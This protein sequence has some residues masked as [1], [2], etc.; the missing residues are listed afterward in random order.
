[1]LWPVAGSGPAVRAWRLGQDGCPFQVPVRN[2]ARS[3]VTDDTRSRGNPP[4]SS[5][6]FLDLG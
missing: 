1:M 3:P 6:Q 2:P 5:V 4:Y